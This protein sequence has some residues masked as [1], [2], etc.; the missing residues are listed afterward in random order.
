M[1]SGLEILIFSVGVMVIFG[2]LA[3]SIHEGRLWQEQNP[4]KLGFKWGYFFIFSTL[5]GNSLLFPTL[6]SFYY[7]DDAGGGALLYV[8]H[9]LLMVLCAIKALQRKRWALV[10]TTLISFNILLFGVNFFYL[11]NRWSEF[12][13]E[14]TEQLEAQ[15]I[16]LGD[17]VEASVIGEFE[18]K[19]HNLSNSWRQMQKQWR[20]ATFGAGVW[21]LGVAVFV[22]FFQPYGGYVSNDEVMDML[23]IMFIPSALA[24]G[25]YWVYEKFVR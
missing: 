11:R 22:F 8:V 10:L 4:G 20:L 19:I 1:S 23:T 13:A 16:N 14:Q 21:V 17:G 24:L 3:F 9:I 12:V 5:V 15:G 25:L 18:E 2:A 6:F 7:G